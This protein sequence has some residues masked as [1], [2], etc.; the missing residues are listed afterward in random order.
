MSV[1]RIEKTGDGGTAYTEDDGEILDNASGKDSIVSMNMWGF[2][3]S[4]LKRIESSVLQHFWMMR[5]EE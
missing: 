5:S 1:L 3:N 2:S 4:I